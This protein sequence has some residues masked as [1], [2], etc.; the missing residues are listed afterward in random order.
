MRHPALSPEQMDEAALLYSEHGWSAADIADHFDVS[1]NAA[2]T[3]LRLRGVEMRPK[4]TATQPLRVKQCPRCLHFLPLGMFSGRD[5]SRE[6]LASWCMDCTAH[7]ADPRPIFNPQP[8]AQVC[9]QW[10]RAS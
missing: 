5:A 6:T 9:Q 1:E 4:G 3:A 10:S 2:R 8:L 7:P